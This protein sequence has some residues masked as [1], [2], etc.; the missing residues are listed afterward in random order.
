MNMWVFSTTLEVLIL[1]IQ[2]RTSSCYFNHYIL[3]MNS[4]DVKKFFLKLYVRKLPIGWKLLQASTK[5]K[6]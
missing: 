5:N 4:T 3:W 1:G 2:I 6:F